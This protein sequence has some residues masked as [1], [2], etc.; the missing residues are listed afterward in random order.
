MITVH[1]LKVI[2]LDLSINDFIDNFLSSKVNNEVFFY[3]LNNKWTNTPK[4]ANTSIGVPANFYGGNCLMLTY[5]LR[6][7][8]PASALFKFH[9]LITLSLPKD[10]MD[11]DAIHYIFQLNLEDNY[12]YKQVSPSWKVLFLNNFPAAAFYQK[13]VGDQRKTLVLTTTEAHSTV[14]P[15]SQQGA[16]DNYIHN[17]E[18]YFESVLTDY[19]NLYGE[20]VKIEN[21]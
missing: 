4:E 19:L 7:Y 11:D 16:L 5:D 9:R 2:D 14:L 6:R 17:M 3:D 1:P 18:N 10:L 13:I 15:Y 8:F 20:E 21:E 12:F